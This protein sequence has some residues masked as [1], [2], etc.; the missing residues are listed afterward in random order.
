MQDNLYNL[1]FERSVLSSIVFEPSQFDE[2][3]VIL[4]KDD[5]YL[6]AHQDI[7]Q[8]MLTLLQKDQPIDE[9]FIKKELIKAK[10]FDEQVLLEILSANPISNTKAYVDEIKDKSL[11]RHLLTLTTEIK[12]V[13]V[14][15]ELPSAEVVDIVE[16]KLYEI[17][18]DNQTSDFK[19]SPKMTFDTMEYIKEMKARG[20]SVLVGVDTG[21]KELNKMTTGFGKG[22]LVIIAARP[23]MGKCLGKGTKVVM[24]DG[25]LKNVEDIKVGDQLMGDDSTP[26]NVLSLAR[27]RE[28]MYWVRQNKGI[29]YR[30]NES[31]ILSLKRSRNEG[32]HKHGDVLNISVKEYNKK[33]NKFHS[34]YKGYKVAID[35]KKQK[36]SIEPYF[37]GIWLGDGTSSNVAVATHDKEVVAYLKDYAKKLNLQ[38]TKQHNNK[39]KCPMYAITSGKRGISKFHDNSLQKKLR[40]LH[41]LNCKHIPHQYLQNSQKN[42]LELL[43]GLIDSDG[44]YDDKFHVFEIVQKDEKLAKQIKFLADSLGFRVSIKTKKARIKKINYACDVYRLK[45]VGHLD[46]IPTKIA[47]KKA[48]KLLSKREHL[49]TGIQVEYDKVDDYYGFTIDGNHLFLLE[50]MTVTHNTSFILNTVNSLILQ[51][52][53]VA[54]FSLEMPAEQ[55]MLRLLS[56]QTSIPLQKLRVGDMNDDQ[57]SNLNGAIDRMNDAKL[58]VD[59]QGSLNINQLRSKLRKL[60]NQHPEIEIAVIDYLQIMQGIGSQDR[61][62]QVSEISRGLKMLAREL[63]MPIVA[64]SQLNRGLE[65]RNDKRPMLSDIRESGSIEQDADIILFVYRD[66]VYLYKEEKEREKAARA[67]GKEF[68]STY[69]EKEEEDAEIIIGKQR[70]GPTGHV[71]LIFQKKLTRFVDAPGYAQGVETV[72]ENVDTK[73]ANIEMPQVE[74]PSI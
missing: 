11:K 48:R 24:F 54:F 14:E 17:T 26:R 7:F 45:I 67:E 22:D 28:K 60:K 16:K 70:N 25:S 47:R 19:D 40:D 66:D 43:A 56:I 59:D 44:Y 33:S 34:N 8:A 27:G 50:D 51:G 2:L 15:E 69:I 4:K 63:E 52:K 37:L 65:S 72:Y 35:F 21:F 55:L 30:V 74:M 68:T 53:G 62:L 61:H 6:P 23:A 57:W 12:R 5:F 49:H 13:T 29:D 58:F 64:L 36:L 46:K 31:H 9:E 20:N 73:S 1:A 39:E 38:V 71:K 41:V 32:K 18:Q 42:R 3:S 10:K